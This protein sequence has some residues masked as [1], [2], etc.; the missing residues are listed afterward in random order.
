MNLSTNYL[1]VTLKNPVIVGACNLSLDKKMA[2]ELQEAGASAIVFKSLFE[3]QLHLEAAELEEDLHEYD[4]RHA[5]MTNIFPKIEHSGPKAHL[6]ALKSLVDAVSIPVFASL[7]CI[8]N[9]SWEEYAVYLSETGVAG[10]ELN[11]YSTVSDDAK[12]ILTI[13]ADQI[14]ALKR[15]KAK[16]RIPVAVKL[17]PFYTNPLAFIKQLD[18]N[19]AN[20]YVLF[21]R[22]FQPDINIDIETLKMSY[23]LSHKGDAR[24]ALRYMGLLSGQVKGSLCA[25]NGILDGEDMIASLLAGADAVQIVS[26]LYKNGSGQISRMVSELSDWM[27]KKGYNALSDFK[28]KMSKENIKEPHA[29]KRAQYVDILMKSKEFS[30]KQ[31]IN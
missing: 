27:Q 12:D 2:I 5:E 11:F 28:G 24:L 7:N 29:Y 14:E 19:G 4:D 23:N 26:T 8:Y 10:L 17:S 30:D 6:L 13:E 15:V 21:N 16:V 3:E 9:E 22:L 1:G 18:Q 25:N 31:P 20:G